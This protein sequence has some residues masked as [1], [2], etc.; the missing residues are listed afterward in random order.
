M[1]RPW[2]EALHLDFAYANGPLVVRDVSVTSTPGSMT[3]VIGANGSGKSTLIRMIAGLL[4]PRAGTIALDGTPLDK[5]E[6]RLR[7]RQIAYVPQSTSTA[8]PFQV[9][10][11]VLSGRTPHAPRFR[12]EGPQDAEKAMEALENAGAAHLASR[13][14]TSLSGGERQIVI[15]ARALA[16]EPQLLLLDE[17]SSSL[18]LKHRADLIRTL[19]RLRGT[20]HLSV[21]MIT[22]DLQLTGSFDQLVALRC[23][24]VTAA[25]TPDEVLRDTLLR[26]IYGDPNVRAQRMGDQ[27]VVWVDL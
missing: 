6:P 14:F 25:G 3:A 23:G 20:K 4:R 13:S 2:F 15:L 21:I 17:P 16:Q 22:H 1:P 27:T 12:F 8:F 18:D 26:D 9:I 5:W 19:V 24:E 10:D 11:I 7:A